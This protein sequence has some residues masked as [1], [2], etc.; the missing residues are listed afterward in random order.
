MNA[1]VETES[2]QTR[3]DSHDGVARRTGKGTSFKFAASAPTERRPRPFNSCQPGNSIVGSGPA[4]PAAAAGAAA[5]P[6]R[7]A[8]AHLA[9]ATQR[10]RRFACRAD[11]DRPNSCG[12][13]CPRPLPPDHSFR[14]AGTGLARCSI[15]KCCSLLLGHR[16]E[17]ESQD[18]TEAGLPAACRLGPAAAIAPKG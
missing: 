18:P 16:M 5:G 15:I 13:R 6:S 10:E 17:S 4:F 2:C 3:S 1:A 8:D 11:A 9:C 12:T 7:G 14:D